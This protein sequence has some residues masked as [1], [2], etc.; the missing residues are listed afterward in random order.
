MM[1]RTDWER[2]HLLRL[3]MEAAWRLKMTDP[4]HGQ[5]DPIFSEVISHGPPADLFVREFELQRIIDGDTLEVTIF[6]GWGDQKLE[7]VRLAWLNCPESRGEE[8]DAGKWVA[9]RVADWFAEH[10]KRGVL[11][12]EVFTLGSFNRCI[13]NVWVGNYCLNEWI[14]STRLAWKTDDR[15][16]LIEPRLLSS[17]NLPEIVT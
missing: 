5:N 10:G 7:R 8:R 4:H 9:G 11:K 12:S 13:A 6:Q 14:L 1:V 15:G 2:K 17:L 16:A 3:G